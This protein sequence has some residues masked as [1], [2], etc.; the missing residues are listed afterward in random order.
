MKEKISKYEYG[1]L[2]EIYK[3]MSETNKKIVDDFCEQCSITAGQSKVSK[4]K[5]VII[6][7][8]D[9]TEIDLDKL[10]KK[11]IDAFLV[12]INH[13]KLSVWTKNEIKVYLKK[14]L[15]WYYKD[16]DMIENIKKEKFDMDYSKVNEN[17]LLTKDDID[18]MYRCSTNHKTSCLLGLLEET[19]GRAGE[20]AQLKFKDVNFNEKYP[21]VTLYTGKNKTSRT[22]PIVRSKEVI[23]KWKHHYSFPDPQPNDFIFVNPLDRTKHITTTA[24]NKTLR[25]LSKKAG[26]N[27]DVWNY[28]FR[29]TQLT[30]LYE[31]LPTPVVEQ[32]AGHKNMSQ[33]YAHISNKKA[34]DMMLKDVYKV[35]DL[36]DEKKHELELKVDRH[37]KLIKALIYQ[38]KVYSKNLQQ[39]LKEDINKEIDFSSDFMIVQNENELSN[40]DFDLLNETYKEYSNI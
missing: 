1:K 29:H 12:I 32:L 18:K 16:L 28:L 39:D 26:I 25:R 40:D 11:N 33:V 9:I 36:D 23:L 20:I 21:T 3:S 37:E 2:D 22:I 14:F 30:R 38:I 8:Y 15:K 13:S 5:R 6:Q 31:T 27:K 19:G 34:R 24:M 17:N 4:I 35:D 10:N 7:L